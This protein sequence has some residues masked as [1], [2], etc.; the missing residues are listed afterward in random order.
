[1]A[2]DYHISLYAGDVLEVWFKLN[3][4]DR[5]AV[6]ELCFTCKKLGICVHLPYASYQEAYCLR[7]DSDCTIKF[8]AAVC[9][10][11]LTAELIDGNRLTLIYD[12]I[13]TIRKKTN[14]LCEED[15]E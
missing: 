11:D 14:K 3:S 8:P 12:G 10:Y 1:M 7:L 6:N 9:Y 5:L 13:L 15:K 2:K 4:I